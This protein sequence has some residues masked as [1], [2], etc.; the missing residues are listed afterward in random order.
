MNKFFFILFLLIE[1]P[2]KNYGYNLFFEGKSDY[3]VLID[4]LASKSEKKAAQEFRDYILRISGVDLKETN[5]MN[6]TTP[7][8]CIGYNYKLSST[9]L[10]NK[11]DEKDENYRY[12]ENEGNIYIW[13][14]RNRGTMYG[15]FAFLEEKLGV[16]WYTPDCTFVP[17]LDEW[18][19]EN[20]DINSKPSFKYRHVYFYDVENDP[21]WCAHNRLNSAWTPKENEYGGLDAYW[22]VHT[23]GKIFPSSSFFGSH[24]EFYS[25]RKGKRIPNGQ[26]CLSNKE[27]LNACIIRFKM[28][29]KLFPGYWVYSLSQNDNELYCECEDCRRLELKYGG[30]SGLLLWF[31]NQVAGAIK[32]DFPNIKVGTLAYGYT[33][34]V[35]S[36]IVPSDNVV[37]RLCD[38]DC[39]FA[40]EIGGCKYND[41]F[42]TQFYEWKRVTDNIFVWDYCANFQH[43][44]SPFPNYKALKYNLKFFD[45]NEVLG[46]MEQGQYRSPGGDFA[47]LKSWILSKLLWDTEAKID[48]LA[49]DFINYYYGS[50]SAHLKEYYKMCQSEIDKNEKLSIVSDVNFSLF[51]KNFINKGLK[52]LNM[53]MDLVKNDD[54]L[55]KRVDYQRLQLLYLNC[56]KYNESRKDGT[57]KEFIRLMKKYKPYFNE[58]NSADSYLKSVGEI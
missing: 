51:N 40:H 13:G 18:S 54:V 44:L 1:I 21:I 10:V 9:L 36:N 42:L 31:V 57:Y 55:M 58:L 16:R 37:I 6:V 12:V 48:S 56:S 46:V 17:N 45:R 19:F 4:S 38:T 15:V 20:F 26:L 34:S 22:N 30:H 24:P 39:C 41:K 43:F 11:P 50:A 25:L 27:L 3:V 5:N 33:R 2:I 23:M 28:H 7:F 49:E 53:A 8:V 47:E 32:K 29:I 35:P 14:G 52:I